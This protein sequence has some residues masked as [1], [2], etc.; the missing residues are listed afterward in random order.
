MQEEANITCFAGGVSKQRLS[1]IS[2]YV[3]RSDNAFFGFLVTRSRSHL[4]A[5]LPEFDHEMFPL[6]LLREASLGTS[7][8]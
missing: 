2:H 1:S 8:S 3:R 4:H 5:C 6:L 7:F